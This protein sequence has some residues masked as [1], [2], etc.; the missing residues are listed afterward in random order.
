MTLKM[1]GEKEECEGKHNFD[2]EKHSIF[3]LNIKL[4]TNKTIKESKRC[5]N[6]WGFQGDKI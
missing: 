6:V 4:K 2:P 1:V 5:E 3:F